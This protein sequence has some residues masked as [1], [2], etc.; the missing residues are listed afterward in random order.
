M[1]FIQFRG[2]KVPG[3]ALANFATASRAQGFHDSTVQQF[4]VMGV[5][6]LENEDETSYSPSYSSSCS[7]SYS[8]FIPAC[9]LKDRAGVNLISGADHNTAVNPQGFAGDKPGFIGRQKKIGVGNIK[10]LPHAS[11]RCPCLHAFNNFRWHSG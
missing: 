6:V 2:S 9:L 7:S 10:W 3:F 1:S 4:H 8:I 5:C 11:Q